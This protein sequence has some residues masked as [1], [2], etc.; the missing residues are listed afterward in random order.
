MTKENLMAQAMAAMHHAY[1]PYSGFQVGAALLCK[2]GSV[3]CGCNIENASYGATICA[4]RTALYQAIYHGQREF[5]AIAVCG[6]KNGTIATLCPPCGI[7]RQVLREFC[8]DAFQV[9]LTDGQGNISTYTLSQ[10]LPHSFS[11]DSM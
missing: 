1:A 5:V 7:C 10:L 4:E 2:D 9:Y 6:G 11:T 8:D 3:Y